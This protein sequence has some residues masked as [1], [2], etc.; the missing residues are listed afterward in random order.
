MPK[1]ATFAH[2]RRDVLEITA[3]IPA[4]KVTTFRAIGAQLDVMPRHVAYILATLEPDEHAALPWHRVVAD[5]DRIGR[6]NNPANIAEQ[7]ALLRAENIAIA[8]N[9]VAELAAVF[10]AVS[11]ETTGVPPGERP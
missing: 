6:P 11:E 1:S 7:E 9:C 10:F 4:G 8:D 3:A 5:D 2:I